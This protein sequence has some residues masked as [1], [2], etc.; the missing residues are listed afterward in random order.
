MTVLRFNRNSDLLAEQT[1]G[2]ILH[3]SPLGDLGYAPCPLC[4]HLATAIARQR[5]TA[6]HFITV[7]EIRRPLFG[8]M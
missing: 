1:T 8:G 6:R 4:P 3:S 5:R 2:G 7:P